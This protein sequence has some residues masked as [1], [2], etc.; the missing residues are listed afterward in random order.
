MAVSRGRYL[1]ARDKEGD[2]WAE[3]GAEG[4]DILRGRITEPEKGRRLLVLSGDQVE[5]LAAWAQ[6]QSLLVPFTG[7]LA[8]EVRAQA[9]LL[10]LTPQNFVVEAVNAFI[11][12]GEMAEHRHA[13]GARSQEIRL[14]GPG[15]PHQGPSAP[16]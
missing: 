14:E 13:E 12:A 6:P 15:E 16:R 10:G 11:Q 3:P 4:I 7:L 5:R 1:I 2:T 9:A 8:R